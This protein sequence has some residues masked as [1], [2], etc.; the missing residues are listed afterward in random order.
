MP[1][2]NLAYLINK[3]RKI[4]GRPSQN[5]L[6]DSEIKDYINLYYQYDLPEQFKSFNL[7]TIYEFETVPNEDRYIFPRETYFNVETPCYASGYPVGYFQSR[8]QFYRNWP[9]LTTSANFATGTG[10]AGPYNGVLSSRP[11][12]K[13]DVLISAFDGGTYLTAQDDGAGNFVGDVVAGTINYLTGAISVTWNAAIPIGTPINVKYC[14][15]QASR[16]L[17]ILFYNDTFILRPIPDA[18][19]KMSL[20]AFVKPTEMFDM[21]SGS[22]EVPRLLEWAQLLAYGASVKIFSD[23]MDMDSFARI[24]PLLTEQ[25]ALIERRTMMQIKTQR[26][27]TVYTQQNFPSYGLVNYY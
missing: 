4:T 22:T 12:I 2:F 14:P 9:Q 13:R 11:I 17:S 7:K 23:N 10:V 24:Q 25:L 21:T 15:Y 18:V 8:E 19:Y 6:S 27:D 1:T 20:Q 3:V 5:Q 16:P 26:V